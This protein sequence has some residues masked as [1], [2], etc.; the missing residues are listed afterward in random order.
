MLSRLGGR[1][2]INSIIQE[3]MTLETWIKSCYEEAIAYSGETLA[4]MMTMDACFILEVFRT[5]I[6]ESN[7]RDSQNFVYFEP[8]FDSQSLRSVEGSA[9]FK[10]ILMLDNQIPLC[11]LKKLY[12]IEMGANEDW[13]TKFYQMLYKGLVSKANP[14]SVEFKEKKHESVC[15]PEKDGGL[16]ILPAKMLSSGGINFKPIGTGTGDHNIRFEKY[17]FN[18]TLFLPT[19][20][21]GDNKEVVLRNLMAFEECQALA[22]NRISRY[23]TLMDY[24]INSDQDVV[25]LRKAGII[26][27]GLRSDKEV[28]DFFN[29]ICRGIAQNKTFVKSIARARPCWGSAGLGDDRFLNLN[30]TI[31]TAG[32]PN[33]HATRCDDRHRD[34]WDIR[35]SVDCT[36]SIPAVSE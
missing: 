9:I 1:R 32:N 34:F 24:L 22:D 15:I 33:Q 26:D 11:A 27:S 31:T 6:T 12:E 14:F 13:E 29:D 4:W 20:N 17:K 23:M 8:V 16:S 21:V 19:I 2:N 35:L 5:S 36:E 25:V 28:A 7:Q 30:P 18:A 3:M 10:D